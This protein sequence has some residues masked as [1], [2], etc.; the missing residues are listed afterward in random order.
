M[1]GL[2]EQVIEQWGA[3]D[4]GSIPWFWLCFKV[5]LFS[6]TADIPL[7]YLHGAKAA[8]IITTDAENENA[9]QICMLKPEGNLSRNMKETTN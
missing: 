6:I 2:K 8:Q 3:S 4:L 9:A 5:N 1:S 7:L